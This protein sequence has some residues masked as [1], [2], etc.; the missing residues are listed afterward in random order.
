MD[1]AV[2]RLQREVSHRVKNHLNAL[3]LTIGRQAEKYPG[4]AQNALK[5]AQSRIQAVLVVHSLLDMQAKSGK[6]E[7][8][9]L[10]PQDYFTKLKKAL[11]EGSLGFEEDQIESTINLAKAPPI[12]FEVIKD[13]GIAVTELAL[14]TFEYAYKGD[15]R[16]WIQFDAQWDNVKG[17]LHLVVA[18]KGKGFLHLDNIQQ[19]GFGMELIKNTVERRY[20]GQFLVKYYCPEEETGSR[21][22]I[23]IP[24][25]NNG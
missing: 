10:S 24:L 11:L 13:L 25:T 14:N 23:I 18:D 3:A 15:E 2:R 1:E 6:E 16:Q 4:S 5:A 12:Y 9:S 7:R 21:F 17:Q 22:E 20:G 19:R 8:N